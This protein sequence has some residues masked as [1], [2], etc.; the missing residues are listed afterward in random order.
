MQNLEKYKSKSLGLIAGT[1]NHLTDFY[2]KSK[3]KI[4][5][6][7]SKDYVLYENGQRHIRKVELF[8]ANEK[9]DE[10]RITHNLSRII[11]TYKE[12]HLEELKTTI[13]PE[14]RTRIEDA[15]SYMNTK[16]EQEISKLANKIAKSRFY[17]Y[18]PRII[19]HGDMHAE[20][21]LVGKIPSGLS[22]F[23][24]ID[25]KHVRIDVPV[26]DTVIFEQ[27]ISCLNERY[28]P[29]LNKM[30]QTKVYDQATEFLFKMKK[31]I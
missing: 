28:L 13:N 29:Q 22:E 3:D 23:K 27:S 15:L 1:L 14:R 18:L 20:N 25:P 30:E 8:S 4:N 11:L 17:E 16:A 2:L 31:L 7:K 24:L 19:I 6:L 26:I 9:W 10:E 21:I 5:N 12:L